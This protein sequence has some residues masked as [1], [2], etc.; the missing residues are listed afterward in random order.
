MINR[1]GHHVLYDD[2][3]LMQ[4]IKDPKT[5][6]VLKQLQDYFDS[7]TIRKHYESRGTCQLDG[8][9]AAERDE[10][11]KL[12]ELTRIWLKA[13]Q[14]GTIVKKRKLRKMQTS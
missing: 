8:L 5:L 13:P 12:I 4:L 14:D 9:K 7:R 2:H 6:G 1:S 11:L 3:E 10:F